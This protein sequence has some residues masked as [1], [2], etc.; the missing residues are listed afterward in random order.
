M[1]RLMILLRVLEG[2]QSLGVGGARGELCRDEHIGMTSENMLPMVHLL[3]IGHNH[4][5]NIWGANIPMVPH[6]RVSYISK[7]PQRASRSKGCPQSRQ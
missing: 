4:P 2:E 7:Q 6:L 3:L 5:Q 1:K